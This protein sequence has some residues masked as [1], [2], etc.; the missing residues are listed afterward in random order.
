MIDKV[1]NVV[2]L[3]ASGT[4]GSLMG[5]LV[6]QTGRRVYFLSR[7]PE[8]AQ[9][10]LARAIKQA[11]SEVIGQNI[12]C[13]RYDDLLAPALAEAD[14]IVECV[15]EDLSVKQSIYEKVDT[16]RHPD[17][18]VSSVTSSLPLELLMQGR[19]EELKKHFLSTHFYNPPG[20]MLACETTG[21]SDTMPE[22]LKFMNEFLSAELRRV[23]IPVKNTA[24]F[25]GNRIAF[26]LL[27]RIAALA[28]EHGVEMMDYLI[29]PYTGRLMSP[30]ATLDLVGI[31]VY[32]AIMHSLQKDTND[33]MHDMLALPDYVNKM[34]NEGLLGAK[35]RD[36]GGFYKRL[37]NK[38]TVFIDPETCDY[39]PAVVPHFTF[40]EKAKDLIHL[41]MYR[42]AFDVIKSSKG[43]EADVVREILCIYIAYAYARIGEVAESEFGIDGINKVMLFGFN[44]AC[45]S[46]I[47]DML[48]GKDF[49]IKLLENNSF[50]VP[51][52]LVKS[53]NV[54]KI[55]S[56]G[57]Y[58][59]AK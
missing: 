31:D 40:V 41:G 24:A 12:V 13:G 46:L 51:D 47:V 43:I 10:G 34:I 21:I 37:E 58:F 17:S 28:M 45:P 8:R 38:K 22:V 35:T 14:W 32:R 54:S 23:I 36:K 30:L 50:A 7:T 1:E 33:E 42:Q 25:A 3:G 6:A 57:K 19:S 9:K 16:L 15:A 5:G 26:L 20:K 29:G 11:R 2:V 39:I 52:E 27:N 44:W 59:L 56:E 55:Y 49:A 18:I 53:D 48:G 4:M